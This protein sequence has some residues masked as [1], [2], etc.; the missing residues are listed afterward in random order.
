MM[1]YQQWLVF[2]EKA[3]SRNQHDPF[4]SPKTDA[5]V[6]LQF[7]TQKSKA[8]ILA[9]AE[10]ELDEK[11]QQ[12]LTVLLNRRCQGEPIAYILGEKAFWSLNLE[13]SPDTLIPRPDTEILVERALQTAIQRLNSAHSTESLDIL[14]LG[15]GSGAI[16][17]ALAAELIPLAEKK[18]IRF[19]ALGVDCVSG[20]VALAKRNGIR[21]RLKQVE[22]LQSDWFAQIGVRKFDIIVSNPPYIDERD[23]HLSQGDVRFEPL[24]AL[25]AEEQGYADLHY[26]IE[27]APHYLKPQGWLLLEHGWR[28]GEKVRSLFAENLWRSIETVR[29]YGDNERVSLAQMVGN[30]NEVLSKSPV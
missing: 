8:H 10:T 15:T 14:D 1:N 27:Q 6:L 12:K 4:I 30:P 26:I 18:R 11:T 20:A 23:E 16:I 24:S 29:D 21:N 25:V 13:V 7:A 17:L 19:S 28:Q 5:I 3:L 22:F 2:A 9:F